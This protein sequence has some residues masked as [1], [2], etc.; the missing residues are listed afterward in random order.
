MK[1]WITVLPMLFGLIIESGSLLSQTNTLKPENINI[2]TK[3]TALLD[4]FEFS[5]LTNA[6]NDGIGKYQG[7]IELTTNAKYN[8]KRPCGK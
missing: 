2:N 1:I 4:Y 7:N 8:N 3:Y 5:L 6:M